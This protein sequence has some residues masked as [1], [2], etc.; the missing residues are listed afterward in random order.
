MITKLIKHLAILMMAVGSASSSF[1]V[2]G[3]DNAGFDSY[4]PPNPTPMWPWVPYGATISL[5]TDL[6]YVYGGSYSARVDSGGAAF[7]GIKQ[8]IWGLPY[9]SHTP[10]AANEL[11]REYKVTARAIVA[12]GSK[13]D[14]RLGLF[15]WDNGA[16]AYMSTQTSPW[17][18]VAPEN[19]WVTLSANFTMTDP[20]AS[21]F[22][23][24]VQSASWLGAGTFYIDATYIETVT[25]LTWVGG[26]ATNAWDSA[27]LNWQDDYLLTPVAFASGSTLRFTDSGN[28]ASPIQ[29]AGAL[30][31]YSLSVTSSINYSFGGSGKIS[32]PAK[33]NKTGTG[34][35]TMANAGN[36]YSGDTIVRGGTLTLGAD[37]V[38]PDGAGKGSFELGPAAIL[39]LNGHNETVNNLF[40]R[41]SMPA[42]LSGYGSS[43]F[44]I[45]SGASCTFTINS[46]TDSSY[47]GGDISGPLTLVKTGPG[48]LQVFN[49]ANSFSGH[50]VI[51]GGSLW[52]REATFFGSGGVTISNN[53]YLTMWG[54]FGGGVI[55]NDFYLYS[56]GGNNSGQV[57]D[58]IYLDS[59]AGA[60]EMSG[61]I[62]L[63]STSDM[64][65]YGN[66][67]LTISGKVT[68]SGA[69]WKANPGVIAQGVTHSNNSIGKV[70][71]SNPL[72][73]FTG[74]VVVHAGTLELQANGTAGSGDVLVW[75]NATLQL[76]SSAALNSAAK[77]FL[78]GTSSVVN[79]AFVGTQ[80]INK[81]SFD[82]G[83]T[84]QAAGTWGAPTSGAANTAAR[85]TG[86]GILNVAVGGSAPQPVIQPLA[87]DN[88]G[89][90][91][92]LAVSSVAGHQY[93]LLH[94]TNLNAPIVWT[95]V[96]TN[97][98]TGGNLTN[99]VPVQ[100]SL[101]QV[102]YR[103]QVN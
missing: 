34:V 21:A 4:P 42:T 87:Y 75:T 56:V 38:I 27:T 44:V 30:A 73:D 28:N 97:S 25:N 35:L 84:F 24:L 88:T 45:N 33:V 15:E 83:S 92:I 65:A 57:K 39:E 6:A 96:A 51:K 13:F 63:M 50:T 90:N 55:P 91:L 77:L 40:S 98:G 20:A 59:T 67:V 69:L 61:T 64:G 14:L 48:Q 86:T 74:G 9:G 43:G 31:P 53:A 70:I 79:L 41:E 58:S 7:T 89:T 54:T 80:N 12:A 66:N 46:L 62:H 18:T 71:L 101:P 47:N 93:L 103:Y 11:L 49:G 85:F 1:G 19:G 99:L 8:D 16:N 36:D 72:N 22:T 102:F 29:L 78:S 26:V 3:F 5:N 68:G 32:G 23:F 10:L 60:M 17:V 2:G 52:L 82:G 100:K 94:A 76:D 37:E 81:L 95:P